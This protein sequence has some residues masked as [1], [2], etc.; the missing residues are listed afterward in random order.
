MR[1]ILLLFFLMF[2]MLAYSQ[3]VIHGKV[4]D[5]N[6]VPVPGA[7][8]VI[9]GKAIGTVADF[10]GNFTLNTSEVPPFTL[11]ITSI[12]FISGTLNI[13]QNN[14][15][16]TVVLNESQTSLD[17]VVISASRTPERIF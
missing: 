14:Q 7:N 8:I 5:Q 1:T 13:A 3:T 12:G 4:V 6:N 17:E 11:N 9:A 15:T 10:D 2:G 16:V